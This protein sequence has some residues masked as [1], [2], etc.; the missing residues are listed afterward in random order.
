M[1]IDK[2]AA[3]L[4]GIASSL[5]KLLGEMAIQRR[6]W[7][8]AAA[9]AAFGFFSNPSRDSFQNLIKAA[10]KA[11]CEDSIRGIALNFLETG[12]SPLPSPGK[13]SAEER[14]KCRMAAANASLFSTAA[15]E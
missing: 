2:T 3:K 8:I 1:G 7:P 11:G 14:R 6:Q 10:A 5:E 9:H 12:A 13:V 15:G 4:P